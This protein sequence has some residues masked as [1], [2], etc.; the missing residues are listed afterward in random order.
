MMEPPIRLLVWSCVA[1]VSAWPLPRCHG[2]RKCGRRP[3]LDLL[4]VIQVGEVQATL[5]VDRPALLVQTGTTA[6]PLRWHSA[7]NHIGL[8]VI[9]YSTIGE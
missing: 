5:L 6:L 9:P 3:G 1:W 8:L 4:L 7:I 2:E